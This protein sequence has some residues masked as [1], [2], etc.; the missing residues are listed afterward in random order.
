[1]EIEDHS[2]TSTTYDKVNP[3]EFTYKMS[4]NE[5]EEF[6]KLRVS[7][8]YLFSGRR[9]TSM[10]A[11]RAILKH[12]GLQHKM[13]HSQASKKWE[14]LKKRYKDLKN[15]PDGV[16]VFPETWPYFNLL[17]DAMEGRLKG[18]APILKALPTNGDF[19]PIYKPKKRKASMVINSP[20]PS[21]AG[22]PEIEVS[23]NGDEDEEEAQDEG[24][25]GMDHT[26]EEMEH[27]RNTMDSERQAMEREKRVIERERL[28]LQRER[29]V[30]DRE[31][32]ALDRD[33]VSLE[34]ERA[35]IEREKAGMERERAMVERD[36]DAVSRERLAL[37]REKAR[38]EK[39]KER[40]E[41]V[42]EESSKV[43]HADVLDRKERFLNLFE[44]LIE[45]F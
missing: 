43:N 5:I 12:M 3:V 45:N 15:P 26:M 19:L 6:V 37:E 40:T 35:T 29:A 18:S 28:V 13:T 32:A 11:W 8:H 36:R 42:T 4:A 25:Q 17:D 2:Y 24:S 7:N 1:M 39:V 41:E 16:K 22:G 44:K 38:L 34:R 27:D 33:R 31:V 20:V 14:N 23:L 21:L 9:N 30:L 10:W